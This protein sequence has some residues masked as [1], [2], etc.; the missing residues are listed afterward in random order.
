MFMRSSGSVSGVV[1]YGGKPKAVRSLTQGVGIQMTSVKA[2]ALPHFILLRSRWQGNLLIYG[3]KLI[4]T[5]L[6]SAVVPC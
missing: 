5:I 3:N 2:N 4:I 6:R 1:R